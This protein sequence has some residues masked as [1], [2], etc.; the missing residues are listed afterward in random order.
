MYAMLQMI[1]HT[2]SVNAVH[3]LQLSL[4][5]S[6]GTGSS[7]GTGSCPGA[8]GHSMAMATAGLFHSNLATEF[9]EPIYAGA[10]NVGE[11]SSGNQLQDLQN[12]HAM[13]MNEQHDSLFCAQY[14]NHACNILSSS[15]S[16]VGI[17]IVY[18][19]GTTWL[20]E[21]FFG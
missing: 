19:G 16:Y 14:D 8:Y 7:P 6:L 15:Y 4:T 9:C 17:G 1:N 11:W 18:Q 13:M 21:D 3:T 10:Q 12:I 5:Q 2:R 20:T